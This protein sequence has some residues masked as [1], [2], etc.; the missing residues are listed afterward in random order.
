[1]R[2]L[3]NF[4]EDIVMFNCKKI[5][6]LALTGALAFTM[7]A[8]AFAVTAKNSTTVTGTYQETTINVSVPTTGTVTINP[9]GLNWEPTKSDGKTTV[10]FENQQILSAPMYIANNSKYD[11]TVNASITTKVNT[12]VTLAAE[13][14]ADSESTDKSAYVYFQMVPIDG[15]EGKN[16]DDDVND[17]VLDACAAD[18]TWTSADK[19]VLD[20]T[21]TVE[22]ASA[23]TL[24]AATTPAVAEV[25]ATETSEKVDAVSATYAKGSVA[26]FRLAGDCVTAPTTAWA[27]KDGF[28]ATIA[29]T[30]TPGNAAASTA[31]K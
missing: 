13:S 21:K 15:A 28:T 10:K 16:T 11:L 17:A 8:P 14:L 25:A 20:S 12:G 1:M 19:L 23:I 7:A 29:F 24:K 31:D 2:Q 9:Y 22:T 3:A 4:E 18:A 27:A 30:F 26:A 5:M 6:S